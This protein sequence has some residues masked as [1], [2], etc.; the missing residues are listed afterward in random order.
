MKSCEMAKAFVKVMD[1]EDYEP[2]KQFLTKDC[3]YKVG[4]VLYSGPDAII[5]T[6]KSHHDFAK[7]TFDSIV[8]KSE[9]SQKSDLEFEVTY[10][11]IITHRQKTHTYKCKQFFFL[12]SENKIT[13][14]TH[15]DIPGEYE[16][17]KA[18]YEEIGLRRL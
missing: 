17:I 12:N 3:R 14:I 15:E 7:S 5:E 9:L 6:Y 2:A 13:Q 16:R 8:Y 18:F 4:E 1:S 10:I 11:D